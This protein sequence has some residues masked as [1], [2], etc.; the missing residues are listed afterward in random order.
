MLYTYIWVVTF[1]GS[2]FSGSADSGESI[3]STS[4][5]QLN[6]FYKDNPLAKGNQADILEVEKK[7]GGKTGNP[8]LKELE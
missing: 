5:S 2:F 4:S 3:F 7:Q 1:R 6:F 8:V